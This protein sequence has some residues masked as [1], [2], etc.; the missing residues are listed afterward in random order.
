MPVTP[1]YFVEH[2]DEAQVLPAH[3]A[4]EDVGLDAVGHEIRLL[5]RGL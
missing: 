4:E 1:P 2:D 3:T 5:Y